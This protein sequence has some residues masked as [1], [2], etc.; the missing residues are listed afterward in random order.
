M[1]E[2]FMVACTL[3][4]ECRNY[5]VPMP[6]DVSA[7][8]CMMQSPMTLARWAE[9]HPGWQPRKWKCDRLSKDT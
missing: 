1:L 6:E 7:F 9:D 5:R 4:G 2:L 3:N 8:Q